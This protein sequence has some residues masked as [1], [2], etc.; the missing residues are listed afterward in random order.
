[1]TE[2][3]I[4]LAFIDSRAFISFSILEDNEDDIMYSDDYC[5]MIAMKVK[6]ESDFPAKCKQYNDAVKLLKRHDS[7]RSEAYIG[8]SPGEA[9]DAM[10]AKEEGHLNSAQIKRRMTTRRNGR[11]Y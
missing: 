9:I 2:T 4:L 7:K 5:K 10:R 1:M 11:F 8:M 6:S 3:T